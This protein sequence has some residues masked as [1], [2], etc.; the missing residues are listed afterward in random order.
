M[1]LNDATISLIK[2]HEGLRLKAYAD[3]GYGWDRATIG[4]GHTAA[5]GPPDV[6]KG[7][8][9]TEEEAEEILRRDLGRVE[10]AVKEA[11]KVPIN[12]NQFGALVSFAFNV[13]TGA[14]RRSTLLLK[15]NAGDYDGA[16]GQ[17]AR[18]NKS[19]G[20][21]LEGLKKR[22]AEEAALFLAKPAKAAQP[23]PP[24]PEERPAA[25]PIPAEPPPPRTEQ[26]AGRIMWGRVGIALA[27]L[28]VVA[29]AVVATLT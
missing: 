9:I 2:S 19:N 7:M 12:A 15:L 14:F 11:V 16:A 3:A 23:A 21:V 10:L 8:V 13:G 29:W 24:Q 27:A 25:T 4:Y 5:A 6:K 18:W 22:R 17:F 28:A 20:K 26:P 1:A